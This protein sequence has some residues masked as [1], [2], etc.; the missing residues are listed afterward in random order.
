MISKPSRIM[1]MSHCVGI[2]LASKVC[3]SLYF[4]AEPAWVWWDEASEGIYRSVIASV[5]SG[6]EW[7]SVCSDAVDEAGVCILLPA[8]EDD[9][10]GDPPAAEPKIDVLNSP[11]GIAG[12]DA[13]KDRGGLKCLGPV[14]CVGGKVPCNAHVWHKD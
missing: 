3:I 7:S 11:F 5:S 6:L 8:D 2:L 13:G 4:V 14:K 12:R 9:Q 1:S 10:D